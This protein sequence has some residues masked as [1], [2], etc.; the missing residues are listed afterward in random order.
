MKSN[1][2]LS[3][4]SKDFHLFQCDK[5]IARHAKVYL[6]HRNNKFAGKKGRGQSNF[7]LPGSPV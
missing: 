2:F 3:A 6:L 1:T 4:T 7:E 5:V